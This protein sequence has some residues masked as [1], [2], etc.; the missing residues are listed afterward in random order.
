[1]ASTHLAI[2]LNDHL[3]GA[4]G[5]LE[6]LGDLEAAYTGTPVGDALVQ[7]HAEIEADRQ[8][9]EHLMERL[10]FTVSVPRKVSAW[11]GEKLAYVKLQLDDKATGAMRLFEGLE[12]LGLGIQGKGGLWRAL[13][14]V[15]E[16]ADELQGI[17]YDHLLQRAKDQHRRVEVMRLD[18]AKEALARSTSDT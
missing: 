12:A 15:S 9:L 6:L 14:F 16:D 2:Y 17:D 13:A 4:E 10:H 1:M 8:Q 7:L 18:A 3:A 5:A 11:L